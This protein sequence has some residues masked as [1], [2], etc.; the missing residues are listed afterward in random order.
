TINVELDLAKIGVVL[1]NAAEL[2]EVI[3]NLIF[4]AVDAMPEGGS[5]TIRSGCAGSEVFIEAID[6]GTGMTSEVRNRCLEPFFS[7]KGEKGT[8][9]GLSMVF[10][11]VTRHEGNVEMS[12]SLGTGTTFRI[13]L[14][15]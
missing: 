1:G 3:T 13:R 11:I 8:G 4:N 6:T 7:T 9:L 12:S 15:V 2:R 14:P 5:I 10:G